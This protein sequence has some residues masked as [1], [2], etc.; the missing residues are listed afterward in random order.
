MNER[1]TKVFSLDGDQYSPGAPL[2][3][4]A[5]AL[6]RDNQTGMIL[7]QIKY[8]SISSKESSSLEKADKF[9]DIPWIVTT[10]IKDE[11]TYIAGGYVEHKTPITVISQ[12]LSHKG[13]GQYVGYLF[14][15]DR[16]SNEQ[17]YIDV[18]NFITRPYWIYT[19]LQHRTPGGVFLAEFHQI[20][21]YPPVV[22]GN[23][24]PENINLEDGIKF[25][26][27]GRDRTYNTNPITGM[28]FK[29]NNDGIYVFFNPDDFTILY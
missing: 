1:F 14:V 4:V 7:A 8:V 23:D 9:A 24:G 6:L 26:I 28:V 18:Y 3:I 19:D 22:K 15:E 12:E 29:N 2:I 11:Q 25:L 21:D 17:Y 13:Y 5:G 16:Q 10:Y 27:V 20:S